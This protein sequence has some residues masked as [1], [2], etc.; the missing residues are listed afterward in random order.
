MIRRSYFLK[1]IAFIFL[2]SCFGFLPLKSTPTIISNTT[3][4][5]TNTTSTVAFEGANY[6]DGDIIFRATANK[7]LLVNVGQNNPASIDPT[8]SVIFQPVIG[9]DVSGPRST[10]LIFDADAN[11]LIQFNLY[12]DLVIT[13]SN[14]DESKLASTENPLDYTNTEIKLTFR[15]HGSTV[16]NMWDGTQVIV[17]S[18]IESSAIPNGTASLVE[19]PIPSSL[20]DRKPLGVVMLIAMDQS[21]EEVINHGMNKVIF[22]RNTPF[23]GGNQDVGFTIGLNSLLTFISS[24]YTGLD[25][26]TASTLIAADQAGPGTAL[27]SY[28]ALAFDVSNFDKGRMLLNIKGHPTTYQSYTDGS[29]VVAGQYLQNNADTSISRPG[30]YSNNTHIRDCVTFTQRAGCMAFFRVI[31]NMAYMY[32]KN[33]ISSTIHYIDSLENNPGS[34]VGVVTVG[35]LTQTTRRGLHIACSNKS[36]SPL[37]TNPY[38]DSAWYTQEIFNS[39]RGANPT[40]PGFVLGINGH[41]E[42][43]HNTFLD[44]EANSQNVAFN[45]VAVGMNTLNSLI[46]AHS[47]TPGNLFK[48]H[49]PSAMLVDGLGSAIVSGAEKIKF[50]AHIQSNVYRSAQLT[51]YGNASSIFRAPL[52]MDEA[53][54]ATGS[55]DGYRLAVTN[56]TLGDGVTALDIEGPFSIGSFEDNGSLTQDY[57]NGLHS[58]SSYPASGIFRMG[59]LQRSY[60]DKEIAVVGGISRYITRPLTIPTNETL[61]LYTRYDRS[62]MLVN[63][64]LD[65]ININYHHDD[66]SRYILPN[67]NQSPPAIMGGERAHFLSTIFNLTTPDIGFLRIYN[68]NIHCHESIC[69]SGLRVVVRELPDVQSPTGQTLSNQSSI[70]LY[71]HGYALD[72]NLK[73]FGRI[74]LLGSMLNQTSGGTNSSYFKNSYFNV[75]RDS[76]QAAFLS[77]NSNVDPINGLKSI[78]ALKTAAEV[79]L[80]TSVNE[81]AIQMFYLGNDSNVEIGWN[82]EVG[83]YRDDQDVTVFPWDHKTA[84][85]ISSST[86]TFNLQANQDNPGTLSFQGDFLYLGGTGPNGETSPHLISSLDLGRVIY[87]GH[88]GKIEITQDTTNPLSP[89]PYIGFSDATIAIKLW[90]SSIPSLSA[91]INLP[92]DQMILK[93]PIRPYGMDMSVLTDGSNPYLRLTTLTGSGL[94]TTVSLAW[95]SISKPSGISANLGFEDETF[96][97]IDRNILPVTMPTSGLLQMST[98]DYLDQLSVS[99]ATLADPFLLYLSGDQN[100]ISQIRELAT[101]Y[102]DLPVPGEGSFAKIFLDQGA[103]VGLGSR[104]WNSKSVNSWNLIGRNFVTLFPNGDC[105]VDLNSDIVVADAQPLRPTTNFGAT[106]V[107]SFGSSIAAYTP[108]HRITFFSHDTKEIRIPSGHELDLSAF[109]QSVITDGKTATQQIAFSGKI[110]LIFEPGSTLRFPALTGLNVSNQPI[111]YLNENAQILFESIQDMANKFV[112][113]PTLKV[114]WRSLQDS[115]RAKTKILGVG[116]IW[117]NKTAKM[118]I[119]DNALVAIEA[120]SVTPSTNITISLQRQGILQI[121]DSNVQ[122]GSLQLGNSHFNSDGTATTIS[123][124]EVSLKLRLASPEC[125]V[126]L[127]RNSFLGIGAGVVDR[128]EDTINGNWRLQPLKYAKNFQLS[129]ISGAFSHNQIFAGTDNNSSLLAFGAISGNIKLECAANADA[130]ILGGGNTIFIGNTAPINTQASTTVNL[131]NT[132]ILPTNNDITDN[133]KNSIM[134]SSI[135]L[136][137]ISTIAGKNALSTLAFVDSTTT[138]T[139]N[140]VSFSESGLNG[141]FGFQG[142]SIDAFKYFSFRDLSI[143][144]NKRFVTLSVDTGTN[145]IGYVLNNLITRTTNLSL[146]NGVKVSD[147]ERVQKGVL[148]VA[149]SNA[150]GSPQK[151]KLPE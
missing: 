92:S 48:T 89:R 25:S 68:S 60:D 137:K 23:H 4:L 58:G 109:G 1:Q 121:G 93:N 118:C 67:V 86:N 41:I 12:S 49:N 77:T 16:F 2:C 142:N 35:S 27:E 43:S 122:G 138:P 44:Y 66:V 131:S 37:A 123:G 69:L 45:P 51:L 124:G 75:F 5:T 31:D 59:S 47:Q 90:K 78:L 63:D 110:K 65:F 114:R 56:E 73:G 46:T 21:R 10:H 83:I 97:S 95:N 112:G 34:E 146:E 113:D 74:F 133:G 120:D 134:N 125:K 104:S 128:F 143:Q 14:V 81:K 149:A 96:R 145:I 26:T 6:F 71:N 40:Q 91:Q 111:L 3:Y 29:L 11:G 87:V 53:N 17:T 136:N 20:V 32:D 22:Q 79:P 55:Y 19:A 100:G 103:R 147:V 126:I 127:G 101:E 139:T 94:G 88:G 135:I 140:Q 82:S 24:N 61:P 106:I 98:G 148:E 62:S 33:A 85:S 151:N 119:N 76:G 107:P 8:N 116:S 72:S 115:S 36:F 38:G 9:D 52:L 129:I 141:G 99:G 132:V 15:G 105:Q 57:T 13:G 64:K 80:N 102:S 39:G 150:N 28:A 30:S 108:N 18:L 42:V 84:A 117:I 70:I 54:P 7:T 50:L 144:E 130:T